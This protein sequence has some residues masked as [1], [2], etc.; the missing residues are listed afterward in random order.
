MMNLNE[1]ISRV[2]ELMGLINEQVSET[3]QC[4]AAGCTGKYTGPEFNNLGDI[5]HQ[6]SNVI[7]KAVAAKLKELYTQGS[8]SKVDFDN[9]KLTTKG[10][11]S[12]NVIYTVDIPFERVSNKCDA[13]TG[14]AH[15]G[16]WGHFPELEK[17]KSELIDYI[18][19]GKTK[20]V[21][22]GNKLY[23]SNLTKTP[24]GLQEYWIQWKHRDYQSDCENNPNATSDKLNTIEI[25]GKDINELRNKLKQQTQ[26][27]S[28]D[29]TSIK[30]DINNYKVS[31]NKGDKKINVISL[32]FDNSGLMDE[33]LEK[34][35]ISNPSLEVI[36]K[37]KTNGL[38]WVLSTI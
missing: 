1:N 9:I 28:I 33:R 18:P 37:G 20:N 31:F 13:M 36:Q 17:R 38:D 12:G 32:L 8:F 29:P 19:Q 35:K 24:E 34:I 22:L 10:M 2:K 30:V 7:T 25:I 27:I 14:F 4:S 15:V 3:P 5:A 6:Y 23:I 26:N 21:I 16:G 11:G